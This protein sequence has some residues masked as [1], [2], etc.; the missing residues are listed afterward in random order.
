MKANVER[1]WNALTR[2]NEIR[3]Y[4]F[5]TTTI[6]DWHVGGSIRFVGEWEGQTYE[7]KGTVLAVEQLKLI[8]Y[9]H[10]SSMSGLA[11]LPE[12]HVVVIYQLEEANGSTT[13][14][15][16]QENCRSEEVQQLAEKN[17][18]TILDSLKQLVESNP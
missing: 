11:D 13:F 3:V 16:T 7:D 14:T 15:L 18:T 4:L 10:W 2:P 1:V 5:G 9:T 17:W 6:T 8:R 12:N